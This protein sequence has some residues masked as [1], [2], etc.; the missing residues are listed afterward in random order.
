MRV[1]VCWTCSLY[2][3][4]QLPQPKGMGAEGNSGGNILLI[5]VDTLRADRLS[6]YGYPS[7]LTPLIDRLAAQG[8]R[9][10]NAYAQ[11]PLTLPSHYS[12]LSGTYP[13][14]HGIRDNSQTVKNGPTLVNEV[15]QRNGYRT[16]AFVGSFI[17]DSRF[18]LGRGFDVYGDD[19]DVS[20]AQGFDLSHVERPA[21]EVVQK[22]LRWIT[23][24]NG[25]YFAWV[26][27]F[28]PHDPY[29]P[30][31]PFKS[32]F[33]RSPYDG[34]IAYVDHAIGILLAGLTE[35]G[36]LANT[37]II[38][39][40]DHGE[41]LGEHR[42]FTH[43][44]FVYDSTLHVP[45]IIR[46]AN[47]L[48][49]GRSIGGLVQS[50]DIAPTILRLVGLQ[51]P[52]EMQGRSLLGLLKLSNDDTKAE[53]TPVNQQAY[54]ET[55]YPLRQFG[56]SEL[57][58][59]RTARYKYIEAPEPE[60][61]DLSTD[62]YETKNLYRH[63][64]SVAAQTREMLRE[65][66]AKYAFTGNS[67]RER[68]PDPESLQ[69]LQSLGYVA[70]VGMKTTSALTTRADPKAKIDV[71]GKIL[72]ALA[73]ANQGQTSLAVRLLEEVLEGAP[74]VLSARLILGLQYEKLGD[75]S[76]AAQQF[77]RVL[78]DDPQNA[79]AAFNL[80]QACLKQGR[81]DEAINWYRYTL[82]TDPTFTQ[83]HNALGIIYRNRKEWSRAAEEFQKALEFG[84]DYTA[85][86]NLS[87][88]FAL[89]GRFDQA[90]EHA[91]E[92][93][94]IEPTKEESYN[95]LGSA[96][97]LKKQMPEA[98]RCYL[99]VIDLNPQSD[100]ALINLAK[101]YMETRR[102]DKARTALQGALKVN[103]NHEVARRL[104]ARLGNAD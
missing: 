89:Q 95:L 55:F 66:T 47:A 70:A 21:E 7:A 28:D 67:G 16:G 40:G 15:L 17:L 72:Q 92:A 39:T 101:V 29:S 63:R 34:E 85:H 27:L 26:H 31:E 68:T 60:L 103:P 73:S 97:F 94:R 35:K 43:G 90:L 61:Y 12:I 23:E 52:Q 71:Y 62:P 81:Q 104:L 24:S 30:P 1:L 5:T 48:E 49:T 102:P 38:L 11:V 98:E 6:C 14:Y 54:F 96:Y 41:G 77:S 79:L 22:A 33:A 78:A 19:F 44:L 50:I 36:L 80:A 64:Q 20:R 2:L 57:R 86:H 58:G 91:Q 45:L 100:T 74:E 59:I 65:H 25:R 69:L 82:K 84:P 18:G 42:E 51:S 76:K 56:W 9:F 13:F 32:R 93:V 8:F 83:S 3:L 75:L 53:Q 10:T 37:H 87:A 46:P 4:L 99:K 88:I